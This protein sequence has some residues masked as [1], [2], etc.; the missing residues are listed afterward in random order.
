MERSGFPETQS[1]VSGNPLRS[2]PEITETSDVWAITYLDDYTHHRDKK[3]R[4]KSDKTSKMKKINRII[5]ICCLLIATVPAVAEIQVLDYIVAIVNDDVIV[6]STLQEKVQ[7]V[8]D[9]WRQKNRR[10][11]PRAQLEKQVLEELIITTLQLQVAKRT[12]I[13]IEDS[14]LNEQL[15]DIA[16]Q[17]QMDLQSFRD[18]VEREGHSFVYFRETLREQMILRALQK[19][20]VVNRITV[21]ERE[22]DN[23]LANQIQQ[24]TASNEYHIWHI[25]I[26]TPEAASPEE[27]KAKEQKAQ[28]VLAKLKAGADFQEMAIS[29]SDARQVIESAGDLG[30]RKAGE[31]PTLFNNVINNMAVGE[32]QGLLRNPSGFHIIKLVDKRDGEKS[33]ITQTQARHILIKTNALVSDSEAQKRLEELKYRIEQGDDFAKLARAYSQDPLSAAK[34]GSL[35]WI[36]PGDLVAE[37]EDVMDSLS[38]NQVS[39]PFKSR[40]GWHIVQVLARRE[41]DNT[42]KAIR[43]KAEQQIRQRKFE[44]ELQSWQRQLR[45]EAYVEYRL[46]DK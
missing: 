37:F 21:T 27:I 32:I 2:I 43:V 14:R 1:M 12:G 25:L 30:W 42:K 8:L 7:L 31:L 9:K 39:E 44:A 36:N 38:E 15:R 18:Q 19:R 45:E 34:G 4:T 17:N 35:D 46:V 16:A 22:I 28:K 10:M 23:F 3:P 26:A 20:Q 5:T 40:Y 41:H 6:N 13:Q 11:P 24:G 33:I 29:V